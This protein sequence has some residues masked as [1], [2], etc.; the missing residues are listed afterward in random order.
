MCVI[1]PWWSGAIHSARSCPHINQKEP[2]M[3]PGATM[4]NRTVTP[5]LENNNAK[6]PADNIKLSGTTRD[7]KNDCVL[8]LYDT[9]KVPVKCISIDNKTE[10]RSPDERSYFFH[11]SYFWCVLRYRGGLGLFCCRCG[12]GVLFSTYSMCDFLTECVFLFFVFTE[13]FFD[14]S[15]RQTAH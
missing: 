1:S 13:P 5:L 15:A 6:L 7:N 11:N 2:A 4:Q 10:F 9:Y 3:I 8:D 12:L 14:L